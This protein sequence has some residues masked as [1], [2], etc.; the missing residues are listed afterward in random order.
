VKEPSKIPGKTVL[1]IKR[2]I[3]F[4]GTEYIE[5]K[6][7]DGVLPNELILMRDPVANFQIFKD[8]YEGKR[9]R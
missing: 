7:R 2:V 9:K 8:Y 5:A 4:E 6:D 3:K 1:A